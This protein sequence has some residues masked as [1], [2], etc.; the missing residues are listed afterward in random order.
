MC[1]PYRGLTF[2]AS[3]REQWNNKHISVSRFYKLVCDIKYHLSSST[4]KL[5]GHIAS[6]DGQT[7]DW[8]LF[9]IVLVNF[10]NSI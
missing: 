2:I 1:Q 4:V 10:T 3:P 6:S 9:I 7:S 5:K 8:S